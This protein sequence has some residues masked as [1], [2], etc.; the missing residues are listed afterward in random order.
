M[1]SQSYWLQ[2]SS[3]TRQK[4]AHALN[5]KRSGGTVVEGNRVVS[6]GYTPDDL[7]AI[8]V[9]QLQEFTGSND[10][11]FYK[12]FDL[13]VKMI[14]NPLI[15]Y[16]KE[17]P[18]SELLP[19]DKIVPGEIIKINDYHKEMVEQIDKDTVESF[20]EDQPQ[21]KKRGRQAKKV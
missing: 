6:D 3:E 19:A 12:L 7:F 17:L 4:V 21:P 2:L 11:D 9:E 13:A 10:T 15:T 8:K 14:E 1:L 5:I 20:G 16:K 18:I